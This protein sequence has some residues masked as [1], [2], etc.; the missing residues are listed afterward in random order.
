[1]LKW[2]RVPPALETMEKERVEIRE[3]GGNK[4]VKGPR[5]VLKVR[6][7]QEKEKNDEVEKAMIQGV[8]K[9]Y[10][11]KLKILGVGYRVEKTGT[12]LKVKL[13][14]KNPIEMEVPTGVE[15][16]VTQ[17]GTVIEGKS[18]LKRTLA[19]YMTKIEEQR[20]ARKDKYRG[21]GVVR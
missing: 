13:G 7:G 18:A 17:N 6:M 12:R 8:S 4:Y 20:P 3:I 15:I 5:G 21:K 9:G 2:I 14:Y 16:E 10:K 11:E 19:Q 1:M